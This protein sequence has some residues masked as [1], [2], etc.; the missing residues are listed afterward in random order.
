MYV[1]GTEVPENA[2]FCSGEC[3]PSGALN[4]SACRYGSPGFVSLP[5]FYGAD[6]SYLEAVEGLAPEQ[7][8]H[9]LSITLEPVSIYNLEFTIYDDRDGQKP[10]FFILIGSRTFAPKNSLIHPDAKKRANY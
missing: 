4:I 7:E 2:C 8:K 6:P 9:E 10:G 5:H 1:I 3:V